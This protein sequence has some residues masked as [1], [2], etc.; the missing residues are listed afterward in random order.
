MK[1]ALGFD[2]AWPDN[3]RYG[4]GDTVRKKSGSSWHG[5]VVGWYSTSLTPLGYA[6]ESYTEKGSVQ[7]YPEHALEPWSP[8]AKFLGV[9]LGKV[10]G[11]FT[12]RVWGTRNADGSLTIDRVEH[13]H[14]PSPER[15]VDP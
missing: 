4:M 14:V 7:I 5:T 10:D 15:K 12:C 8:R 3:A 13:V 1:N 11:D 2:E 9:D 6:V